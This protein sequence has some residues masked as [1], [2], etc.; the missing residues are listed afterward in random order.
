MA[1][2]TQ[3]KTIKLEMQRIKNETFVA[4]GVSI[5]TLEGI[6]GMPNRCVYWPQ[7]YKQLTLH[8][9]ELCN[10]LYNGKIGNN[11]FSSQLL[12]YCS[13]FIIYY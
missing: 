7:I 13:P 11:R 6:V 9:H 8:G 3:M 2:R 10:H 12:L 4:D 5:A 1:E